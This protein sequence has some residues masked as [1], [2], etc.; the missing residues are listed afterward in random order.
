M[1]I[2]IKRLLLSTGEK[3]HLGCQFRRRTRS[4]RFTTA[5][6]H[7][8]TYFF[9]RLPC[10]VATRLAEHYAPVR[11]CE[12]GGLCEVASAKPA[13]CATGQRDLA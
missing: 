7:F 5:L 13:T 9:T 11:M 6:Y 2:W 8:V 1:L 10:H 3:V 12:S 4:V